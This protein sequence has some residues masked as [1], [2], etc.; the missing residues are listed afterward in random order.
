MTN[1][2]SCLRENEK[3]E[4]EKRMYDRVGELEAN[5][6]RGHGIVGGGGQR[7]DVDWG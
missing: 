5:S 4:R 2:F 7:E 1:R 6:E 3:R